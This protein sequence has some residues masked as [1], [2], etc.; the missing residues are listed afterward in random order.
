MSWALTNAPCS[1]NNLTISFSQQALSWIKCRGLQRELLTALTSAPYS[2][3]ACKISTLGFS[4]AICRMA[5]SYLSTARTHSASLFD[6]DALNRML[7]TSLMSPFLTATTSSADS[8]SM[9]YNKSTFRVP[10][11]FWGKKSID[12]DDYMLYELG[13][14]AGFLA[15][16]LWDSCLSVCFS[17]FP[18]LCPSHSRRPQLQYLG[19]DRL[20]I[21]TLTASTIIGY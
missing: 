2:I 5:L 9:V 11:S 19:R 13:L 10:R 8:P 17:L 21:G 12:T 6:F 20:D 16:P 4:H 18:S 14:V 7:R 15:H 1:N 3:R